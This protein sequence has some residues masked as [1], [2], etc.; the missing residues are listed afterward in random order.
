MNRAMKL[1]AEARPD[2]LAVPAPTSA[3]PRRRWVL[4]LGPALAAVAIAAYMGT[5]T[6]TTPPSG[7]PAPV[8]MSAQ[9]FLL[10]AADATAS[11]STQDGAYW[12]TVSEDHL[13]YDVGRYNVQGR[14]YREV[15]WPTRPGRMV[16]IG[17]WLGAEPATD[18]DRAAWIADGSPKSW[19]LDPNHS[20]KSITAG[21][22]PRTV[23]SSPVGTFSL[24][25][26][27][28][29]YD[30]VRALPADPAQLK[31]LILSSAQN[32]GPDLVFLSARTLLSQTPL[33]PNV[34]AAVY[35]MLAAEP[36]LTLDQNVGDAN[37]RKGTAVTA[38]IPSDP[39]PFRIRYIIDPR[40]G[41]LLSIESQGSATLSLKAEFRGGPPPTH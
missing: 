8:S 2:D 6:A 40:T 16:A 4:A 3:K 15:W 14:N 19:S 36:G 5:P 39:K 41:A 9:Q 26:G 38:V 7:D 23:E 24:P 30:Q 20:A 13:L 17:Q 34:R 11:Q 25:W 22:R 33:T 27:E 1:L 37:G 35:R 32:P 21:Q 10:A 12:V 29:T 28:L 31:A 18:S